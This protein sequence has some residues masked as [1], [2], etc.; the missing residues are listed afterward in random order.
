M[1]R[2]LCRC[3]EF[4]YLYLAYRTQDENQQSFYIILFCFLLFID[5]VV[6]G[7]LRWREQKAKLNKKK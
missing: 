1:G 6:I 7:Q 4:G 5:L 3:A 2:F